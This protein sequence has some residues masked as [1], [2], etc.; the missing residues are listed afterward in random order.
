MKNYIFSII[1]FTVLEALCL[2]AVAQPP[3]KISYQAVIRGANNNLVV[4]RSIGVKIS[5]LQRFP[6]GIPVYM[7]THQVTTNANG[8]MSI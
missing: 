4:N 6:A 1:I 5:I 3:Q 2:T 7:E 8:L